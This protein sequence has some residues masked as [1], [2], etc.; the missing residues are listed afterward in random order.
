MT[1]DPKLPNVQETLEG[2][3]AASDKLA[4]AIDLTRESNKN[5][6]TCW[7]DK[8]FNTKLQK[9]KEQK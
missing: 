3:K 9:Y 4:A 2:L 5:L 6:K 7:V 8:V 1:D